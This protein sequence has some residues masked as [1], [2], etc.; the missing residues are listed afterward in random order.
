MPH[1]DG[2][3]GTREPAET[4]DER[5]TRLLAKYADAVSDNVVVV[6]LDTNAVSPLATVLDV[7][8]PPRLL[9]RCALFVA[10]V[11]VT[12]AV[13][14]CMN[15]RIFDGIM[16]HGNMYSVLH[17]EYQQPDPELPRSAT[18]Q[19]RQRMQACFNQ[20]RQHVSELLDLAHAARARA[21]TMTDSPSLAS[22]AIASP[23]LSSLPSHMTSP[24][25]HTPV[26]RHSEAAAFGSSPMIGV[27]TPAYGVSPATMNALNSD[28]DV[29]DPM[30]GMCACV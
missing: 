15:F 24:Q 14:C 21:G 23:A 28:E 22:P 19:E 13:M 11:S 12:V 30:A 4:P 2:V 9:H 29:S 17:P 18:V 8:L 25:P 1:N 20:V 5:A 3:Q 16:R 7:Q 6:D 10:H 27:A 26:S